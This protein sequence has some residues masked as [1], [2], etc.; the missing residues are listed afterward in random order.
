[1]ADYTVQDEEHEQYDI[2]IEFDECV[3]AVEAHL[4]L[5]TVIYSSYPPT[6]GDILQG[7]Q[8]ACKIWFSHLLWKT[9]MWPTCERQIFLLEGMLETDSLLKYQITKSGWSYVL[10]PLNF[11]S[12]QFNKVLKSGVTTE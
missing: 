7:A 8:V 11:S 1:M 9:T 12:S 2:L 10:R 6:F 5:W 4:Q 3:A